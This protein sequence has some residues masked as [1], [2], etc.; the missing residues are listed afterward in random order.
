MRA[1]TSCVAFGRLMTEAGYT[2]ASISA[3]MAVLIHSYLVAVGQCHVLLVQSVQLHLDLQPIACVRE[4][5]VHGATREGVVHFDAN[6]LIHL[7]KV[8]PVVRA[9]KVNT[10]RREHMHV[11]C[12]RRRTCC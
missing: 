11:L 9:R 3:T 1:I 10:V 6:Q 8:G 7:L 12:V 2:Q 5:Y 4:H